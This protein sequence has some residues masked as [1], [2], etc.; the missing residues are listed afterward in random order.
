MMINCVFRLEITLEHENVT[1]PLHS[2]GIRKL[3]ELRP[4]NVPLERENT[5]SAWNSRY[6]A[7]LWD[8]PALHPDAAP[9]GPGRLTR[10]E[11]L[12]TASGAPVYP[13]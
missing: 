1:V 13:P 9:L 3:H 6:H 8:K 7:F 5:V 2:F 4:W 10:P 12:L 11:S